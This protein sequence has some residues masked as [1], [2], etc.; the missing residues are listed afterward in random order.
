MPPPPC[1]LWRA[2][3]S[4]STVA[5]PRGAGPPGQWPRHTLGG[6]GARAALMPC[7]P[8]G[9]SK[10]SVLRAG[11]HLPPASGSGPS[12]PRNSF[13]SERKCFVLFLFVS[14]PTACWF[15][16]H[17]S[18]IH[19]LLVH[20]CVCECVCECVCVCA[21]GVSVSACRL[22][23]AVRL[24]VQMLFSLDPASLW[25]LHL[26]GPRPGTWRGDVVSGTSGSS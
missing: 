10:G 15:S 12:R 25:S 26:P 22:L 5:R 21:C 19:H 1:F 16:V 13:P 23:M 4:A 17:L 8:Q 18:N 6:R 24:A 9:F 3:A 11:T 2:P 14:Y 20:V 7:L